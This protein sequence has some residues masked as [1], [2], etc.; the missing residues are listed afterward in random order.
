MERLGAAA[1]GAGPARSGRL[2]DRGDS[3]LAVP[4]QLTSAKEHP[5]AIVF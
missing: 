2:H 3:P 1:P 5:D 4:W